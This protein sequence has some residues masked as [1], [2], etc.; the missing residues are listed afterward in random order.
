MFTIL[1][2]VTISLL[3]LI[4][5][6]QQVATTC[7]KNST[8]FSGIKNTNASFFTDYTYLYDSELDYLVY[9]MTKIELCT[10]STG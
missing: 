4:T 3:A 10:N 2:F 7:L 5:Q 9:R 1:S 6:A 8:G